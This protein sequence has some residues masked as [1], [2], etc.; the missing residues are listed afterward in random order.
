MSGPAAVASIDVTMA[1]D[2]DRV[3]RQSMTIIVQANGY[4]KVTAT[5]KR[6]EA[7]RFPDFMATMAVATKPIATMPRK[8]PWVKADPTATSYYVYDKAGRRSPMS[9]VLWLVTEYF[10][11]CRRPVGGGNAGA[12]RQRGERRG[13]G[14]LGD[15]A[16]WKWRRSARPPSAS[17]NSS[18]KIP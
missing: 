6:S 18:W 5:T 10:R 7:G 13:A 3:R 14:A 17:D 16:N 11:R 2:R 1:G 8:P 4:T 15:P 12:G 9:M